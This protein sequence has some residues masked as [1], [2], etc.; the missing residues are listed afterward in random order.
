MKYRNWYH[1]N[2]V[3]VIRV[4]PFLRTQKLALQRQSLTANYSGEPRGSGTARSAE[5]AAI[6]T[7]AP[8][9]E[10]ALEAV[11]RAMEAVR[12]WPDGELYADLFEAYYWRG[13]GR[14]LDCADRRYISERQA[15]AR[16]AQFQQMVAK[17][18]RLQ[19]GK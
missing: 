3:R 12:L 18:L 1:A 19:Q 17:G 5:N 10:E 16:N 15:R 8:A 11:E 4:Y 6:K 2:V 9:E 14:F 13:E 7:L